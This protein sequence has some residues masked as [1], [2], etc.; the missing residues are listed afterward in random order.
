MEES[1]SMLCARVVRGMSSTENAVTPACGDLLHDFR[2]TEGPQKTNQHLPA[3]HQGK[4]GFAGNVIRSVAQHLHNDVGGA[5]YC[6]AVRHNLRAFFDIDCVRI[7]SLLARSR[8]DNDFEP[9]LRRG[10]E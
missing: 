7:A 8:F 6:G 1:A 3:A 10:W 2:G 9:G 5:E 4:I